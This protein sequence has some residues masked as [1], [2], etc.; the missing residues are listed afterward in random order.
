V[1]AHTTVDNNYYAPLF[2]LVD[3]ESG[4]PMA[5][6]DAAILLTNPLRF[7][8]VMANWRRARLV[9]QKHATAVL[10]ED[11]DFDL[12]MY[13]VLQASMTVLIDPAFD[14]NPNLIG[15]VKVVDIRE[16]QAQAATRGG[17]APA[18]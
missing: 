13:E 11:R 15:G 7:T 18:G 10:A 5:I 4:R 3:E 17:P 9:V 16:I 8:Q 6:D 1:L 2:H 12:F 14:C